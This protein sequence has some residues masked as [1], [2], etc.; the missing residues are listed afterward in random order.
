MDCFVTG[1]L[2]PNTLAF[3]VPPSFSKPIIQTYFEQLYGV[4]VINV[5]TLN[6]DPRIKEFDGGVKSRRKAWKKAFITFAKPFEMNWKAVNDAPFLLYANNQVH[7][8]RRGHKPKGGK[9]N[10]MQ[11]RQ[12]TTDIKSKEAAPQTKK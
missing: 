5:N 3:R 1:G 12:D 11:E 6:N 4:E 9:L 10:T 7:M 8:K 2:G